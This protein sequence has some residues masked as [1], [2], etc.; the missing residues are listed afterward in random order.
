MKTKK[1]AMPKPPMK[2]SPMNTGS[3]NSTL[4]LASNDPMWIF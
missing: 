3:V 2:V 4:A 1:L